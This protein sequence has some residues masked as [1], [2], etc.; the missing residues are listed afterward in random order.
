MFYINPISEFQKNING[1]QET[2][3]QEQVID[4]A[5]LDFNGHSFKGAVESRAGYI[6]GQIDVL[7]A[8]GIK[9]Y[10]QGDII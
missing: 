6:A 3:S 7:I 1:F 9:Q 10:G 2:K 5:A 8:F 4:T